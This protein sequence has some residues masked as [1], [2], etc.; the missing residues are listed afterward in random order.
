MSLALL[1]TA[2]VSPASAED[3]PEARI[4]ELTSW[5]TGSFSSSAQALADPDNYF[6]IRLEMVEIWED[7][8]DGPWLY[9]EQA[10]ASAL[11]RPYR[12]RI[13]RLSAHGEMIRSDVYTL[14][15]DPLEY[16]G[17]WRSPSRF[18]TF[19]PD[20]LGLRDGCS[21]YLVPFDGVYAGSTDG[22]G[23]ASSLAG[24]SYA[25]SVVS[26]YPDVLE[27]WDRGFDA[28]GQQVWGAEKGA[29]VFVR[30]SR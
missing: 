1:P 23:C 15:G 18:D 9:I 13:Y 28:D 22:T 7:R 11:E 26:I 6:D 27:S 25:T 12:Q 8:M 16:A 2:C 14:P 21:I 5:M 29:Y 30:N 4:A 24:A 10:A 3:S 19:G 17:A 20:D